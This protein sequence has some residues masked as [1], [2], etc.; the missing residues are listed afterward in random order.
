[1]DSIEA[2]STPWSVSTQ[3]ITKNLQVSPPQGLSQTEASQRLQK[4][5]PNQLRKHK[6]KH[7]GQIFI[8]QFKSLIILLLII[9]A[10]VSFWYG[11]IPEGWAVIVVI[12]INTAIGFF[13]ELR[14]IRSMEALFKLGTV[15]TRV[16][17]DGSVKEI[18]AKNLVPGDI[19]PIEGGDVITTDIRIIE[20]SKLQVNESALTGESMPVNKSVDPI[21]EETILAERTSMLYKGT[22]ISRGSAECIVIATGSHTELGHISL[23]VESAEKDQTPLEE[24]LDKLGHRLIG[25]TLIIA[26]FVSISGI[27]SD[28]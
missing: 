22:A 12:V 3:E 10:G 9:A 25:V 26:L 14:A 1:M 2:A 28:K 20:S 6:T 27:I 7:I 13:T 16:R 19:V 15:T 17:R 4:F 18:D 11:K 24:R 21:P 5:G 23:M 8:D